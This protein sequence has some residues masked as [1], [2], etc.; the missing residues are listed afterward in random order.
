VSGMD[1]SR[2][3]CLKGLASVAASIG[4][5][6]GRVRAAEAKSDPAFVSAMELAAGLRAGLWDARDVAD[7]LLRRIERLNGPFESF[8]DNGELNAFIRIFREQALADAALGGRNSPT[9]PWAGVPVALK[10]IFDVRSLPATGGT[11]AFRAYRASED[12]AVWKRWRDAGAVLLGQTQSQRFLTG[13]TTPQTANPWNRRLIAGGSSGGSA[14]AVAAGLVPIA[15]GSET[16]GSLIYPAACCGVTTLK[17]SHGLLSLEGVYPG[18]PSFD[19][20]GP[21][22]RTAADC[23]WFMSTMASADSARSPPA[24]SRLPLRG[25]R[26]LVATDERYSNLRTHAPGSVDARIREAFDGFLEALERLGARIVQAPIPRDIGRYGAFRTEKDARMGDMS[27]FEVIMTRDEVTGHYPGLHRRLE[28][29]TGSDRA[30]VVRFYDGRD[31]RLESDEFLERARRASPQAVELARASRED[32]RR[33]WEGLL[34]SH[35]C[36]AHVYLEIG[37]P[38]PARK[39]LEDTPPPD[40]SREG[41]V[42]CDL[43]WPV[44]S[45]PIGK[46]AGLDAPV[47]VQLMA[48]RWQDERLLAWGM[49]WQSH[50]PETVLTPP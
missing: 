20:V 33:S 50:H 29:A 17:P 8:S 15:L 9:R 40:A 41:V 24:K 30:A 11:P 28:G 25:L 32:L 35:E 6:S 13:L 48:R 44:L 42:P 49:E 18:L 2:R 37:S 19:V 12:C 43:G 7:S 4:P 21:I 47:S 10:D 5:L 39:G 26:F 16:D 31:N 46:P 36:D 1:P 38:L 23:A 14:A 27:A 45:L 3:S 22:A 34:L